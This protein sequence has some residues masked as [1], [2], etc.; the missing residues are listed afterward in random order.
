MQEEQ[1]PYLTSWPMSSVGT[2]Q[3]AGCG[4]G[5]KHNVRNTPGVP[6]SPKT[7]T[8]LP[9]AGFLLAPWASHLEKKGPIYPAVLCCMPACGKL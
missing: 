6:G 2:G 7:G 3:R 8:L 9:A 1:G 5:N 4:N